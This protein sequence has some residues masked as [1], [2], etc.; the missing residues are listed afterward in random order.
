MAGKTIKSEVGNIQNNLKIIRGA[1]YKYDLFIKS[2]GFMKR[3][4]LKSKHN[5]KTM[6]KMIDAGTFKLPKEKDWFGEDG[7][8]HIKI[9]GTKYGY[10]TCSALVTDY[11]RFSTKFNSS[12][13]ELDARI[14]GLS[15]LA[16]NAKKCFTNEK[17]NIE[18]A[19]EKSDKL[20]FKSEKKIKKKVKICETSCDKMITKLDYVSNGLLLK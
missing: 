2:S 9:N 1:D 3:H 5:V 8:G 16:S 11:N 4:D 7:E 18:T 20:V 14:K 15:N 6:L 12:M 13:K 10:S 19:Y 17:K